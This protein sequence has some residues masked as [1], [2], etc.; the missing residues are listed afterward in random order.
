VRA[1]CG[2]QQWRSSPRSPPTA[3]GTASALQQQRPA[4]AEVVSRRMIW[5]DGADARRDQG[6]GW[7]ERRSPGWSSAGEGGPIGGDT[8]GQPLPRKPLSRHVERSPAR[9]M[10]RSSDVAPSH[11]Q[12]CPLT[13]RTPKVSVI[14]PSGE[15]RRAEGWVTGKLGRGAALCFALDWRSSVPDEVRVRRR[16]GI[17]H[18]TVETIRGARAPSEV[19]V[20]AGSGHD[21]ACLICKLAR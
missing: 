12:A 18:T 3:A 8:R 15:R 11:D 14:T 16:Q 2:A 21:H 7:R 1:P 19:V 10:Q 4:S 9:S 5:K 20:P 6:P 13:S 17:S